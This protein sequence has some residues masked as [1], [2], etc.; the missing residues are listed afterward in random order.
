MGYSYG[1]TIFNINCPFINLGR[2]LLQIHLL[3][4]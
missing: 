2:P 3:V 1:L 4:M